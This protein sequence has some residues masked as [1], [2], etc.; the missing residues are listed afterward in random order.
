MGWESIRGHS[1]YLNSHISSSFC[2]HTQLLVW[3]AVIMHNLNTYNV[4]VYE[5][6]WTCIMWAETGD[7]KSPSP[8]MVFLQIT[9]KFWLNLCPV[10]FVLI[11]ILTTALSEKRHQVNW[12]I[13]VLWKCLLITNSHSNNNQP[14]AVKSV[15]L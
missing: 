15:F 10:T 3:K 4:N 12:T 11:Y 7:R 6:I 14:W 5:L 1:K 8:I 2:E 13:G 9:L